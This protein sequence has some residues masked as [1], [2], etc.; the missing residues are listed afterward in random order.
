M[1]RRL[2]LPIRTNKASYNANIFMLSVRK[3]YFV[4]NVIAWIIFANYFI[5]TIG[6]WVFKK[7]AISKVFIFST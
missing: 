6:R 2:R 7:L 4:V 5:H 1:E 3:L